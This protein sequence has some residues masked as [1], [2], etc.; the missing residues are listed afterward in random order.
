MSELKFRTLPEILEK[1]ESNIKPEK[2]KETEVSISR[3]KLNNKFVVSFLVSG[4]GITIGSIIYGM[5]NKNKQPKYAEEF[6]NN[7][8]V[9]IK[10]KYKLDPKTF[11]PFAPIESL[12]RSAENDYKLKIP[13]AGKTVGTALQ[14]ETRKVN[15]SIRN[16][17][18]F[19]LEDLFIPDEY[20]KDVPEE[21]KKLDSLN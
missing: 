14:I 18:K 21:N 11:D 19:K 8:P 15:D 17:L 13:Y 5:S 3:K 6:I 10:D 12:P 20:Y 7:L 16:E 4:I 2:V 9:E 1:L